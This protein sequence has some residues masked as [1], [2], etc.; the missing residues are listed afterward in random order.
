M[1]S[2][3][4]WLQRLFELRQI[5]F[6]IGDGE[7]FDAAAV[8]KFLRGAGVVAVVAFAGEDQDQIVRSA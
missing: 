3:G 8:Q 2:A 5:G 1:M 6:R 7:H 4:F